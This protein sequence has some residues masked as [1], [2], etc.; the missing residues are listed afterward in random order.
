MGNRE[1]R[2][3]GKKI[4]SKIHVLQKQKWQPL[5]GSPVSS[6]VHCSVSEMNDVCERS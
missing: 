3:R 6:N 5:S 4:Y 2:H 1:S